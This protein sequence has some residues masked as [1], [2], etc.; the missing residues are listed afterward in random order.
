MTTLAN[1]VLYFVSPGGFDS[2]LL[3]GV[4]DAGVDVVQLRMKDAEASHVLAEG[5]RF[6]GVCA[7]SA[8][9]FVVNDRPDIAIAVEATGVHL[10]QDDLPPA[11]ARSILGPA[12]MI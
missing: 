4:I 9:P 6:K 1:A 11:I 7:A 12:A 10:G 2:D 3:A 5:E 8:T